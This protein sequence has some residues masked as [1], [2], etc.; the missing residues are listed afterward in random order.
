MTGVSVRETNV[1]T[2]IVIVTVMANSRKIL[3]TMPPINRSGMNTA[4]SDSVIDTT[5]KLTSRA[6][7]SAASNGGTPFSRCLETFSRTTIASS[8]TKP[9]AT[10]NAIRE[11]LSRL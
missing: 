1:D 10:V 5:V 3:P 7:F 11:R 9:V 8:T 4:I 2:T 6:P